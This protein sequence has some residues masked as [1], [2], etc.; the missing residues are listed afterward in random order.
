MRDV[1]RHPNV[2]INFKSLRGAHCVILCA[3][4]FDLT[5]CTSTSSSISQCHDNV[6]S[7]TSG[8]EWKSLVPE[9]RLKEAEAESPEFR[10]LGVDLLT[11]MY[12]EAR[13]STLIQ[14]CM[15]AKGYTFDPEGGWNGGNQGPIE[16]A[17]DPGKWKR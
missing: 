16:R 10:D 4:V 7:Q 6:V 17:T 12:K 14:E 2:A 13:L 5:G 8:T 3:S 9:G 15:E 11:R 1:R